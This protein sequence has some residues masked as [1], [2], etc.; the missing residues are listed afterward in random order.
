MQQTSRKFFRSLVNELSSCHSPIEAESLV[1]WLLEDIAEISKQDVLVD[2]N[3]DLSDEIIE[4][5]GKALSRL[6]NHEPIQH[7]LGYSYFYGRKFI[8]NKDV[9]IP[10]QETEEL[11]SWILEETGENKC[12]LLDIG[13]GTGIIPITIA[14]ENENARCFGWDVSKYTLKTAR[15]NNQTNGTRVIF[16]EVNILDKVASSRQFD[17]IVS[18]PPYVLESE[19]KSLSKNVLDYDPQIAL[20]VPD[21]D[22]LKFY[23]AIAI[24]AKDHLRKG[25]RLYFEINER[26]GAE[27][28][29]LLGG[30]EYR[31]IELRQDLNKKDRMVKAV[32][33]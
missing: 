21:A 9:L 12:E 10:R 24:F 31:E 26:F 30:F 20:F 7:I 8:V 32:L 29:Q 1:Y 28:C 16:E 6:K 25:G 11:V 13:T 22:P 5:L 27:V 23:K 2:R 4:E 17:V 3:V 14:A 15:K 18:N 33:D 19:K